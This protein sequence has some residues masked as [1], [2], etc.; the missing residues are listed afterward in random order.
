MSTSNPTP[1]RNFGLLGLYTTIGFPAARRADF[2]NG[3]WGTRSW[4]YAG[5]L[6]EAFHHTG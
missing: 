6:I 5:S 4:A 3:L 2:G 1:L